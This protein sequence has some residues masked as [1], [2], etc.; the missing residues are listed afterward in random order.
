MRFGLILLLATPV[1]P[2]AA[3]AAPALASLTISIWPDYDRPEALVIYHFEVAA[4][5][6]LPATLELPLPGS[7]ARPH[8]VAYLGENEQLLNADYRYE[9]RGNEGVLSVT[10]PGPKGQVEYYAPLARQGDTRRLRL[11]LTSP[12]DVAAVS[13][14]VQQPRDAKDLHTTPTAGETSTRADGLTYHRGALRP[15]KAGQTL[16]FELTYDKSGDALTAGQP[17]DAAPMIASTPAVIP[18]TTDAVETSGDWFYFAAGAVLLVVLL[19]LWRGR[20]ARPS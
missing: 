15:V 12:L 11:A 18:P 14:E 17:V 4:T 7:V 2:R 19:A 5:A 9:V 1:L 20:M 6:I 8:A 10:M 3:T 13:V 16:R